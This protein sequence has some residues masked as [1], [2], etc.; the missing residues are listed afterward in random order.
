MSTSNRKPSEQRVAID[1]TVAPFAEWLSRHG[2]A[3][4]ELANHVTARLR[5]SGRHL[6]A[7]AR[8]RYVRQVLLGTFLAKLAELHR[9][10]DIASLRRHAP[11][12]LRLG[13]LAV[14]AVGYAG[15]FRRTL[16][17]FVRGR[18]H[19]KLG[20]TVGSAEDFTGY[21]AENSDRMLDL[22]LRNFN[23]GIKGASGKAVK[24]LQTTAVSWYLVKRTRPIGE[25]VPNLRTYLERSKRLDQRT[26]L[27]IKLAYCPAELSYAERVILRKQ[28]GMKGHHLMIIPIK[29]IAVNLRY[30][31]A[32]SLSRKLYRV[33]AWCRTSGLPRGKGR[34]S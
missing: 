30:R 31:S 17:R 33:R 34:G 21:V 7:T 26:A 15:A 9:G 10:A 8:E 23:S 29:Q 12:D 18:M 16:P 22:F 14:I 27:A 5:A 3:P 28:Y 24:Y 13:M 19:A 1:R 20:M 2:Y 4:D 25:D 6:P 11:D 32:A